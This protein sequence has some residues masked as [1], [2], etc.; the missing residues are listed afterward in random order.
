LAKEDLIEKYGLGFGKNNGFG[1]FGLLNRIEADGIFIPKEALSPYW[2][3]WGKGSE[4]IVPFFHGDYN[5]RI[6]LES[7]KNKEYALA[8]T[9]RRW[10]PQ[11]LESRDLVEQ[12]IR[13]GKDMWET[14]VTG[15]EKKKDGVRTVGSPDKWDRPPQPQNVT[16]L[17]RRLIAY[18]SELVSEPV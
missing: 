12:G 7:W 14:C 13:F 2:G 16:E 10:Q 1:F 3:G 17:A 9:N 4:R 6:G 8:L 11:D 5:N 18:Y 15:F